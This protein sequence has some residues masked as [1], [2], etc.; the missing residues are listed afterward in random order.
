MKSAYQSK[1]CL[2][3][4]I[5]LLY[6]GVTPLSAN[7]AFSKIRLTGLYDEFN[8]SEPFAPHRYCVTARP[9]RYGANTITWV[10]A[11]LIAEY[12]NTPLYS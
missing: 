11:M 8:G 10:S 5:G 6:I 3:Q 4:I 1:S 12:T 9:D 7:E 2:L